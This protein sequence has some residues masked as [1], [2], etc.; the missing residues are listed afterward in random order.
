MKDKFYIIGL[1]NKDNP[2]DD[3]TNHYIETKWTL[4]SAIRKAQ[5]YVNKRNCDVAC[6]F[7]EGSFNIIYEIERNVEDGK[8]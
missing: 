1:K 8:L 4:G 2:C 6:V 7:H 3:R 5:R